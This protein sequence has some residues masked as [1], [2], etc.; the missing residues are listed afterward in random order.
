M[1]MVVVMVMLMMVKM[2][3]VKMMMVKMMVKM[4]MVMMMMMI[5]WLSRCF[6]IMVLVLGWPIYQG[7]I[8][9]EIKQTMKITSVFGPHQLILRRSFIIAQIV[10]RRSF[11]NLWKCVGE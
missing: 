3:M 2:V 8:Q 4:M 7:L 11:L 10:M 1:K 9:R 6:C 5:M